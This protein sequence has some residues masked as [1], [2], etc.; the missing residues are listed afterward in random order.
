VASLIG[1]DEWTNLTGLAGAAP[2][3][4]L[5]GAAAA[6]A[7]AAL[8]ERFV[9]IRYRVQMSIKAEADVYPL[10]RK[11]EVILAAVA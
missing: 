1:A 4:L 6:G 7:A 8:C 2:W 10:W 3:E 5:G 9:D 11:F